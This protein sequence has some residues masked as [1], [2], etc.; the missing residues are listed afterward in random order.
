M[1]TSIFEKASGFLR[2]KG[3]YAV[4]L[5]GVLAVTAAGWRMALP[6]FT[7]ERELVCGL[8]EHVHTE[9]CFPPLEPEADGETD[10]IGGG[11][12]PGMDS[13]PGEGGLT[14]GGTTEKVLACPFEGKEA[15]AHTADCY[16]TGK[17][18]TCGQEE[19]AGGHTHGDGCYTTAKE[20]TCGQEELEGHAH[21]ASCYQTETNLACGQEE[22]AGHSHGDGCY[23]GT[24][25]VTCGQEEG[26]GGHAHSDACYNSEERLICGKEEAAGH[27]HGE[28]CYTE[29]KVPTCGQEEAA[30][31]AHT[32][33]CYEEE[34]KLIC[35]KEEYNPEDHIHGEGCYIEKPAA[36]EN[37]EPDGNMPGGNEMPGGN[38]Q[39]GGDGINESNTENGATTED[40]TGIEPQPICGLEEHTHTD[41]CYGAEVM[42]IADNVVAYGEWWQLDDEGLLTIT[43]TD[44]MTEIPSYGRTTYEQRPWQD[45]IDQV[46]SVKIEG[47]RKIGDYAFSTCPQLTA[48]EIS[49]GMEELGAGSFYDCRMLTSINLP[50]SLKTMG[51]YAFYSCYELTDINIPEGI[52]EIQDSTFKSCTRLTRISIPEGVTKIGESAFYA[53]DELTSINL[54]ET[55]TAI[56]KFAFRDC[57]SLIEMEL[58]ESIVQIGD[59]AFQYCSSLNSIKLP[60]GLMRIENYTF[61]SCGR[62]ANVNLPESLTEIG[63]GA[64]SGCSV[65]SNINWPEG[66]S[67]IG[68]DAFNKCGGLEEFEF[69]VNLNTIGARALNSCNG[70]E[71]IIIKGGRLNAASNIGISPSNIREVDIHCD[72]VDELSDVVLKWWTAAEVS[73]E[74]EGCFNLDATLPLGRPVR[75]ELQSGNYYADG[76]GVLYLLKDGTAS[77]AYVPPG[78][79]QYTVKSRI[80]AANGESGEWVV[81]SVERDALKMA[82]D[83]QALD[84][85]KQEDITELPDY[86]CG[87]CI[88]LISV[89]GENTVMEVEESFTN[90][91]IVISPLAFYNTGLEGDAPDLADGEIEI[92]IDGQKLLT[93]S[94]RK[95]EGDAGSGLELYTGEQ[96]MTT[97][98]LS[99]QLNETDYTVARCYFSFENKDGVTRYGQNSG[100]DY[101]FI[102][103]DKQNNSYTVKARKSSVPNVYYYEI[104]RPK[105][106]GTLSLMLPSWYASP[107][108]A[109]GKVKIWPVLL[110]DETRENLGNGVAGDGGKHH[111]VSWVTE[112]NVFS[113]AKTLYTNSRISPSI[114]G[115][116]EEGKLYLKSLAY[117]IET[118]NENNAPADKGKDYVLSADYTDTLLLPDGMQWREEVLEAIEAGKCYWNKNN[119]IYVVI[120]NDS[121]LLCKFNG[122]LSNVN[123]KMPKVE[124]QEGNKSF[125]KIKWNLKNSSNK[126]ITVYKDWVLY[127]G[128]EVIYVDI[129]Q[130]TDD[131]EY[132]YNVENEI[133]M[134]QHFTHSKDMSV[135]ARETTKVQ[136][137]EGNCEVAKGSDY[138]SPSGNRSWGDGYQYLIT[139]MNSG[140]FPYKGLESVYDRL[141]QYLY[142]RPADMEL[143]IHEAEKKAG[144]KKLEIKISNAVLCKTESTD[145]GYYPGK[146]V[147]GT[148]GKKYTLTQQDTGIGTEYNA[149][150][151][152]FD[153]A[154]EMEAIQ[155]SIIWEREKG[156]T[157]ISP[158]GTKEIKESTNISKELEGI[159]YVVTSKAQYTVSWALENFLLYSGRDEIFSIPVTI[160][161]SFMLME[162][163]ILEKRSETSFWLEKNTAVAKAGAKEHEGNVTHRENGQSHTPQR[164][165]TL[166]KGMK[167][168]N[169]E[170]D[171]DKETALSGDVLNYMLRVEHKK[172]PLRG[173]VP[174]VDRMRGAQALLIPVEENRHL[175]GEGLEKITVN[176]NEYYLL[177]KEGSYTNII[178]G[179]CLTDNITVTKQENGELDTMIRWYLA[180]IQGN[181]TK[182]IDYEA[183]VLPSLG[184]KDGS[185]SLSNES[186]LNDHQSHR[187]YDEVGIRGTNAIIEKMIVA[188]QGESKKPGEDELTE[189]SPVYEGTATTYRLKIENIGLERQI[190]GSDIYDVLPLNEGFEWSKENVKIS[191]YEAGD[192]AYTLAGGDDWQ[193]VKDEDN[194]CRIVWGEGFKL[195]L[196]GTIYI[197]V[198]LEWPEGDEWEAY[199]RTCGMER[200]E[201]TFWC[202]KLWDKVSHDLVAGTEAYLQKGVVYSFSGDIEDD[203]G[204]RFF[205]TNMDASNNDKDVVYYIVIYNSGFTRLYLNELQD[206]LPRGFSIK[207]QN[208]FY[209]LSYGNEINITDASGN[210]I[211]PRW[212]Q[213]EKTVRMLDDG[214]IGIQLAN[215]GEEK[216]GYL[217]YDKMNQKYY[218][219][220]G[221]AIDIIYTCYPGRYADTDDIATNLVTMP[222]EDITGGGLEK[223]DLA[224]EGPNVWEWNINTLKNDG[225]CY[226][227]TTEEAQKQGF[228][229]GETDTLWLTSD[230]DVKRRE[231]IPGIAKRLAGIEAADGSTSNLGYANAGDTV[232]WAIT[233]TNSGKEPITDYTITDAMESPY[234]YTGTVSYKI[235]SPSGYMS[236]YL[237]HILFE[238]TDCQDKNGRM[239]LTLKKASGAGSNNW[240]W[241]KN[242]VTMNSN[243]LELQGEDII[244]IKYTVWS[245]YVHDAWVWEYDV[246]LSGDK[247]KEELNIRCRSSEMSIPPQGKST[248]TLST[249][250]IT[251]QHRN[252]T[253]SNKCYITPEQQPYDIDLVTQGNNTEH[254]G[255]P[256]V[257]S[258][259]RIQVSYGFTT[260]S[261][262]RVEEVDNPENNAVSEEEKNYI[263]LPGEGSLF[264]YTLAVDNTKTNQEAMEKLVLIDSLP[265]V[266][267]HNPFTTEEPRFSGLRV[268]LAENPQFEVWISKEGEASVRLDESQYR[269]EYSSKTEFGE[270]DWSGEGTDGWNGDMDSMDRTSIRSFRVV[271]LDNGVEGSG[272]LIPA[273][274]S[275]EVKFT[276]EIASGEGS[277]PPMPGETAWNGFGYRYSLKGEGADLESTPLNV[278][279]RRPDVPK[280]IKE[281]EDIEG[282]PASAAADMPFRFLIYQGEKLNLRKNF[283]DKELADALLDSN[284]E[285]TCV[286]IEVKSGNSQSEMLVLKD[287][288]K[289]EYSSGG[290]T[291]EGDPENGA[292]AGEWRPTEESWL[293]K[294]KEKYT[295][296]ELPA[297]E[298]DTYQFQ[299]LGGIKNNGYTFTHSD[300]QGK[301]IIAVNSCESS[302]SYELPETGG[303][304]SHGYTLAGCLCLMAGGLYMAARWHLYR[305][306]QRAD[307]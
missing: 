105:E 122:S 91:N 274:A 213:A 136:P 102:I 275:V 302:A 76:T 14:G 202:Y 15:H 132:N 158:K 235:E 120:G 27:T 57:S 225:D 97:L 251:N 114:G 68:E 201:N 135:T 36:G 279:V 294:D 96:A 242:G 41:A 173:I 229:G 211:T 191:Y 29:T 64:F 127:F 300:G 40:G 182:R 231:I 61:A 45:Y 133:E 305:K 121:L 283:T 5:T 38:T 116:T 151:T 226:L 217:H 128:D 287:L 117:K 188:S 94:T 195:T 194:R 82:D 124:R 277:E 297:E 2:G 169:Q 37:G 238:I 216:E 174:L 141:S 77:L 190:K 255:K 156:V 147:V 111:Q 186:W 80:P 208:T 232:N 146:E 153:P 65:L 178:L 145:R 292:A 50:E 210:E 179:G 264:R 89:N 71:R 247:G 55:L 290:E 203:E 286:E 260:S 33:G 299:S 106:G 162:Q 273:G 90:P 289:W 34:S 59:C 43:A 270:A 83:L 130:D 307:R 222:Y 196:K 165:Y 118:S 139:L 164:D 215:Y 51:K 92:T 181:G 209:S 223:A 42:A 212:V 85:E 160:K 24:G 198:T 224:V 10:G 269:L 220:P 126:E 47:M 88:S 266:G 248:L 234:G 258:M 101:D 228:D 72:S 177:S 192:G 150:D 107:T 250:N 257:S 70:L 66:V 249:R 155:V 237:N 240:V 261:Q 163:D 32:E 39:G 171:T 291:G 119:E 13:Q 3:K 239:C 218:L 110:T 161:D 1:G 99:G 293:W 207:L 87:N 288:K 256:S 166:E 12:N 154:K 123:W 95:R 54:P 303:M 19:G 189:Y 243:E 26:N 296:V 138:R 115:G 74:G 28:S 159:G 84:F 180:D 168:N 175:S 284:R 204:S 67:F 16:E 108:S 183:Y 109:G 4:A 62:L 187:L 304:G 52:G 125:L 131:F 53:C 60:E 214:K 63:N 200:V 227:M 11:G 22:T 104:P 46:K 148:D 23:D 140:S 9:A 268:N 205:Y 17:K 142:I 244:S 221:E 219:N 44:T 21:D 197:Y 241:K 167:K 184:G 172:N 112:R 78:L 306:K 58:P 152:G 271:I 6:G 18:L 246:C 280:L 282:S 185:F 73:F 48:V 259:A 49:E 25:A 35:G 79:T 193:I 31:H 86:C 285:F 103:T 252:K 199:V 245:S 263:I 236:D 278:G 149:E 93:M 56:G 170:V 75:G 295:I 206:K 262:K 276:G 267:D 30:G 230:V 20:L 301:K 265:Q 81:C 129:P 134:V 254:H 233:M 298:T 100:D 137:S 157:L 281:L 69:G 176:G 7:L 143:M 113:V 144:V 98:N 272:D 253:Y 8:E